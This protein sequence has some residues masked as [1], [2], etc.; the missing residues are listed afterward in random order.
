MFLR[1]HFLDL[2]K[3][4]AYQLLFINDFIRENEARELDCSDATAKK[5][6]KDFI[7][8]IFKLLMH[9]NIHWYAF[10]TGTSLSASS[11]K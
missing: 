3:K 5:T 10:V 11:D 1:T 7:V 8:D 6:K 2:P 4:E 9:L